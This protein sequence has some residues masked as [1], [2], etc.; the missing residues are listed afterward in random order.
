MTSTA[1]EQ[2]AHVAGFEHLHRVDPVLAALIDERPDYDP[3]A[4]RTTLPDMD[5]F[6]CLVYQVLGQQ[7]SVRAAGSIFDRLCSLFGERPPRPA[8]LR[9]TDRQTLRDLGFSYRKADTVLELSQAFLDGRL[10]EDELDLLP[11]DEIIERLTAIK[12]IGPWTVHGAL[13]IRL[14]RSD[15]VPVG[16]LTLRQAVRTYYGLDHLPTEAE[17]LAVAE[18]WRPHGSLGANLL[19]AALELDHH[20]D[21]PREPAG[22]ADPTRRSSTGGT[23]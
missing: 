14:R 2:A 23:A 16:D 5:L 10:A 22:P 8:E 12:G 9:R 4:W 18:P 6:G 3:D 17:M 21:G 1:T 20:D 19:F 15:V 7:I 11:D 13:I